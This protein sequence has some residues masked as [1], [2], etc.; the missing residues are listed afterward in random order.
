[1]Q[2]L[3]SFDRCLAQRHA[4]AAPAA[5]SDNRP[6]LNR[7]LIGPLADQVLPLAAAADALTLLKLAHRIGP[8]DWL[9]VLAEEGSRHTPAW[10]LAVCRAEGGL[11]WLSP[12]W[13]ARA[14]TAP[15]QLQAELQTRAVQALWAQGW[16][17]L[18]GVP[19]LSTP[20]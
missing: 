17:V 15:Q 9:G 6:S 13:H 11:E 12:A 10:R 4:F 1:M 16:R 18:D 20:D 3:A 19:A 7:Y 5:R 2:G 14:G 8:G